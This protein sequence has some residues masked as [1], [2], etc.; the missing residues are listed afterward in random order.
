MSVDSET[1]DKM[2]EY[3]RFISGTLQPQLQTAVDARD[4]TEAEIAEYVQLRNKLQFMENTQN[5]NEGSKILPINTLVDI[6]H[7]TIYCNATIP[8]PRI[9][10]V[11]VGNGFHVEFTLQEAVAFIDK[12]LKY[13]E[14]DVLKHRSEVAE[15]IASDV[16][17]A[18][19]L[20]EELGGEMS[21]S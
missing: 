9:V 3:A 7:A 5:A 15:G 4:E 10:Y 21:E 18:L 13:L 8:N 16:E 12:R 2:Q 20:L 17:K 1:R 6:S 14:D 11:N 19:E